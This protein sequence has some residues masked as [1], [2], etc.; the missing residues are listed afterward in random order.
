MKEAVLS[1]KVLVL[2]KTRLPY[3]VDTDESKLQLGAVLFQIHRNSER[4][5]LGLFSSTLL[6]AETIYYVTEFD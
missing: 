2:S 5:S 6:G 3:C 4:K 1:P